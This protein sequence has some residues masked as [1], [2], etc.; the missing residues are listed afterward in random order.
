[1]P[2]GSQIEASDGRVVAYDSLIDEIMRRLQA[3][4]ANG[5]DTWSVQETD[6]QGNV[7]ERPVSQYEYVSAKFDSE[8]MNYLAALTIGGEPIRVQLTMD[9]QYAPWVA[10]LDSEVRKQRDGSPYIYVERESIDGESLIESVEALDQATAAMPGELQHSTHRSLYEPMRQRINDM[11]AQIEQSGVPIV[12]SAALYDLPLYDA[13]QANCDNPALMRVEPN[14]ELAYTDLVDWIQQE[15]VAL[16]T[17]DAPQDVTEQDYISDR[18]DAALTYIFEYGLRRMHSVGT[19]LNLN[20][21]RGSFTPW[22]NN[23][24]ALANRY[25]QEYPDAPPVLH[26]EWHARVESLHGSR[27]KTSTSSGRHGQAA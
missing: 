26:I 9:H 4:Y 21:E 14:T 20:I 24:L 15:L 10:R 22:I 6:E 7:H 2:V 12:V 27:Q 8:L 13:L 19:T 5:V 1:M 18:F 3:Q 23:L 17:E 16:Y 25:T 11:I